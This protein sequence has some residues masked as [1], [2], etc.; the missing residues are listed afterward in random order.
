MIQGFHSTVYTHEP[1]ATCGARPCSR[2]TC[3]MRQST[4]KISPTTCK[5]HM[6]DV[7]H[8]SSSSSSSSTFDGNLRLAC[9]S[10]TTDSLHGLQECENNYTRALSAVH[11]TSL[12]VVWIPR[13]D[14]D[15]SIRGHDSSRSVLSIVLLLNAFQGWLLSETSSLVLPES[16][17]TKL[18]FAIFQSFNQSAAVI[19]RP[20]LILLR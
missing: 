18:R 6:S 16:P 20:Y 8:S 2:L 10:W 7:L 4:W 5:F 3:I 14:D 11:T 19:T 9:S 1:Q 17:Y 13:R 12:T 15:S